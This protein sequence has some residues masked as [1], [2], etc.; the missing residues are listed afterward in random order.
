[1]LAN[2]PQPLL[3]VEGLVVRIGSGETAY[4]VVRGVSFQVQPG[5]TLCI[6]GESGSGKTLTALT[7]LGLHAD[8]V[9]IASGRIGLDGR[10]LVDLPEREFSALRGDRIAM[11]FQDPMTSLNPVLTVGEQIIEVISAHRKGRG[12][13]QLRKEAIDLLKLVGIP[14]AAER[15]DAY[16]HQLSG[17][18]RQRILIAMAVAN[19]PRII[20]ADEPTTALD[21]TVQAQVMDVMRAAVANS[22]AAL[23]LITHDMGLVAE[24]ADRVLV[25][26]AGRIVES[27]SVYDVF[28]QPRHPYTR[29]L[30]A[31]IP[32]LE[33]DPDE[34]LEALGGEP[35]RLSDL[36]PGCSFLPRCKLSEGR[37]ACQRQDPQL[38][39]IAAGHAAACHFAE[40]LVEQL[41]QHGDTP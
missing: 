8:P 37:A 2:P 32:R 35:P 38:R 28:R 4:D 14:G 39:E 33:G 12:R 5:E 31:S 22:G 20:V 9:R 15:I 36:P 34:S 1:M 13:S 40:E 29:A 17:G 19:R 18:M 16:P 10:E 23:L 41:I 3:N 7:L 21:V 27:G 25:M 26:Y 24:T 30:L 6:V 11:V